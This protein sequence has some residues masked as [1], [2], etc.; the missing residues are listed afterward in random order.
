[1][2]SFNLL[3][4]DRNT[5]RY[6]QPTHLASGQFCEIV[7]EIRTDDPTFAAFFYLWLGA[8]Q[9]FT[10]TAQAGLRFVSYSVRRREHKKTH[11]AYWYCQARVKGKVKQRYLGRL[12]DISILKFEECI[13]HYADMGR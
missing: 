10:V 12:E 2:T 9:T 11:N 1:M 4:L 8:G 5:F 3:D 6:L 13:R 7:K